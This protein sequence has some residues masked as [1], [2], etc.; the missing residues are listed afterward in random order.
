MELIST[1]EG[2]KSL[3]HLPGT[4]RLHA[5]MADPFVGRIE[6]RAVRVECLP[7]FE[8]SLRDIVVMPGQAFVLSFLGGR[9]GDGRTYF[10]Y[11]SSAPEVASRGLR[12]E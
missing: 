11:V 7:R 4:Y 5:D 8:P 9:K 12:G 2:Y 3:C 10:D 1:C 6:S